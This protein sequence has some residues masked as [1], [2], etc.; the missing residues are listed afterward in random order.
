V[1]ETIAKVTD[2]LKGGT[3][4]AGADT[5]AKGGEANSGGEAGAGKPSK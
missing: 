2:R 1:Q 3:T 4:T 5:T